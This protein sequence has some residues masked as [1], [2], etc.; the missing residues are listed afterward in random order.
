MLS[1]IVHD[2]R[3]GCRQLLGAKGLATVAILTFAIG[4]GANAAIFSI[5]HQVLIAPLPYQDPDDL[6]KIW[7]NR[8]ATR[9]WVRTFQESKE[10]AAVS[11]VTGSS[12][13]LIG[14]GPARPLQGASVT[15]NHFDVFGVRPILGRG[16]VP[17]DEPV[18]ADPVVIL[19]H[20]LWQ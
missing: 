4:I 5:V 9:G 6:V 3:Y 19:S 13:T 11:A 15:A 14:N 1:S 2:L 20:A 10:L 17:E 18:G 16:F 12:A 7:R 8:G